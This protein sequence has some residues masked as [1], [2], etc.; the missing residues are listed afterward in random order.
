[1]KMATP[2]LLVKP[3]K[4]AFYVIPAMNKDTDLTSVRTGKI[5]E[6]KIPNH[7]QSAE[8]PA[9]KADQPHVAPL[10][11]TPEKTRT[12]KDEPNEDDLYMDDRVESADDEHDPQ[13]LEEIQTYVDA[14]N[15]YTPTQVEQAFAEVQAANEITPF[16]TKGNDNNLSVIG[17]RLTKETARA[18]ALIM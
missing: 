14:L 16:Q 13:Y 6:R 9:P 8:P 4:L 2:N 3:L 12:E 5:S 17:W 18:E 15:G 1:T 11:N 10:N 7:T